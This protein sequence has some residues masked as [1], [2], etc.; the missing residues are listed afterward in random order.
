MRDIYRF[1]LKGL[2]LLIRCCCVFL[3][4]VRMCLFLLVFPCCELSLFSHCRSLYARCSL[5][6]VR[7]S[8]WM[9]SPCQRLSIP[10]SVNENRDHLCTHASSG[11]RCE[12]SKKKPPPANRFFSN[13]APKH[14]FY[15]SSSIC[16]PFFIVFAHIFLSPPRPARNS[17][18][19]SRGS[20]KVYI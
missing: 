1:F 3:H 6:H 5:V 15:F 2:L 7:L 19:G 20:T 17:D 13:G 11:G 8:V 4:K 16:I 12:F 18:P 10:F 14:P 9:L